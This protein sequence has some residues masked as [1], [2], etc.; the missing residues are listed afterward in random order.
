MRALAADARTWA[1][2]VLLSLIVG[3]VGPFG[4]YEMPVMAR[5]AY[6]IAVVFGTSVVGTFFASTLET[7]IG[8]RLHRLPRAA[9]AGAIAGIPVALVVLLVNLLLYGPV[10]P[11]GLVT[12]APYCTAICAAVTVAS[13]MFAGRGDHASSAPADVVPALLQRLPLPQ[14]GRLLH[15]AVA[16]HY[17]E[18]TTDRGRTLLLLRL[19]DAI[20]ET[21]PVAGLQVHRS[22]WIALDAVRKA[23][24]QSGKP[25][26]E[27]ENGTVVPI[28]RSFLAD[29][30][31]AGVVT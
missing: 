14:R 11:M 19:S 26:V 29:A 13:A 22:H 18:V 6:W 10:Q 23:S 25:V 31:A 15:L 1:V 9:I 17:V 7:V 16:D 28:S 5:L 4:T 20:R 2:L 8:P 3:L 24:R 27:L 21:A 30:R 12:L